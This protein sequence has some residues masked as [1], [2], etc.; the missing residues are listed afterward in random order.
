MM[1]KA[2][3]RFLVTCIAVTA[4]AATASSC[5]R[6]E[7]K[8]PPPPKV[9]VSK[10]VQKTIT[11]YLEFTGNASAIN[12]VKLRARVEGYLE[13]V[14]FQDGDHVK[15][16]QPLFLIQQNTY[17]AKLKAAEAQIL[18]N[19]AELEHAQTEYDRYA[20]LAKK[21]AASQ[22]DVDKW[23]YQR[24]AAA[25]SVISAEA[26]R[27]LA[28]LNLDYTTV[29]APFDGRIDR[30]LK[31]PGNLVGSGEETVLAEI[32][33]ID[34]IYVYFT[35][36]ERDLLGVRSEHKSSED[37][38][39]KD[40]KVPVSIGLTNEDGYP[41][42]GVLDFAAITVDP[43]TGTLL[44][45]G[46][47]ENPKSEILPGLFA[48]VK[49]PM[50]ADKAA[51]LV[52]EAAIGYDQLGPYVYVLGDKNM[53]E[54]RGVKLGTQ[55]GAMHVVKEGLTGQ[56]SVIVDGIMHAIPGREVTPVEAQ[57]GSAGESK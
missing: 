10:P 32:N 2:I 14:F 28:R 45:R 55:Q 38:A 33:Q 21:A 25:A 49:V 26:N 18:A 19:K 54:R 44:L 9:T 42:E 39:F 46:I 31:D 40:R 17:E 36:N 22:T 48:R 24:D 34:P 37:A 52:P 56:E 4:V 11:D 16:D 35:I 30:R 20:D 7:Y 6:N 15:K 51:I 12:T 13:K 47:F 53:V 3:S 57:T 29:N 8:A 50:S 41:H 5:G 27:D 23:H 43:T 1:K